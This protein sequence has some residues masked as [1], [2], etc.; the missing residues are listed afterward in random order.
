M[1][2]ACNMICCASDEFDSCG[3]DHCGHPD[4]QARCEDCGQPQGYCDCDY[5]DDWPYDQNHIGGVTDM[6]K[7]R[8]R[9]RK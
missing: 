8:L 7:T 5:D 9:K 6:V 3:C 1:C 2:N 4:C